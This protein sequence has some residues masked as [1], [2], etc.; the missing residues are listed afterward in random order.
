MKEK[1]NS[2]SWLVTQEDI[3]KCHQ[4]GFQAGCSYHSCSLLGGVWGETVTEYYPQSH[5]LE[6][7][8]QRLC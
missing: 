5:S 4:A 2:R 3:L 6:P 8:P 1:E 7:F